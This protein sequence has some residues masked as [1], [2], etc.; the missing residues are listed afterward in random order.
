[1][2]PAMRGNTRPCPTAC[3]IPKSAGARPSHFYFGNRTGAM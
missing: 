3:M 1:L 2:S